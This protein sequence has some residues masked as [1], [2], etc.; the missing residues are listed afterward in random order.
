MSSWCWV[1]T[2]QMLALNYNSTITATQADGVQAVFG[3]TVNIGSS[4]PLEAASAANYFLG[5][6]N[7]TSVTIGYSTMGKVLTEQ[8]LINYID[9]GDVVGIYAGFY[10]GNDVTDIRAGGHAFLVYGYEQVSGV[11]QF[12]IYDPMPVNVGEAYR[13]TYAQLRAHYE[14]Y[15]EDSSLEKLYFWDGFFAA[16]NSFINDT[17]SITGG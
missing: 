2:A 16:N 17:I 9:N 5:T 6:V 3:T 12:F 8:A 14:N 11:Y 1:A 10:M 13:L 15:D 4:H 7:N